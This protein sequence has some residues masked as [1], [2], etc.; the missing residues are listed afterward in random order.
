LAVTDMPAL[1]AKAEAWRT[2]FGGG[3]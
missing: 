2:L 3:P 1:L